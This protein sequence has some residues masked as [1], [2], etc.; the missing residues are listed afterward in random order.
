M[1]ACA[2]AGPALISLTGVAR[3]YSSGALEV[4]ALKGV[5]LSIQA[6][7]MVAIVGASGSGKSTLMNLLGC[8][9]VPSQG[10][11][12]ID[13]VA[14]R[15]LSLDALARLRR[16]R[17]GFIFQRY[18]LIR[19]QD[20]L[21][22]VCMP[23]IYA[24]VPAAQRRER[25]GALLARLGLSDRMDHRPSEL[26]GGQQ[27]RVSIARALMN[28]G[29][30][31]LADEPTGA[32]DSRSGRD[33]VDLLKELNQQGHTVII[34]THDAAVAAHA[35]RVIKLEDGRVIS[36]S[37]W[38]AD[39]QRMRFEAKPA[40]ATSRGLRWR[41]VAQAWNAVSMAGVALARHR[42]RTLL[43]TL[44]IGVGIAAVVGVMA[45]GDAMRSSIEK[46]MRSFIGNKLTVVS[47][48]LDMLPGQV[49]KPFSEEDV[50]AL[51]QLE[52]VKAVR[53]K[54]EIQLTAR[55]DRR[56]EDL[57]V[58]GLAPADLASQGH[59]LQQG[60]DI[61]ELDQQ[62]RNQV[63]VLNFK[64]AQLFFPQVAKPVGRTIALGRL[65]FEVIGVTD[66]GL[67]TSMDASWRPMALVPDATLVV[68]ML[69]RTD[70]NELTVYMAEGAQPSNVQAQ[71][72]RVLAQRHGQT[73]F[74]VFN[75][76][77]QLREA[78]QASDMMRLVLT[79]IASISLLVGG[80]GVM[81]MMLVAVSERTSEIGIRMAVG[82]RPADVQTQFLVES[83]VLC[84]LGGLLGLALSWWVVWGINQF[85]ADLHAV[86]SWHAM[87]T[88]F[89]VSSAIGLVFG[90]VPARQA[91]RMS[92]VAALSR[93]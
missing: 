16:E 85:Q 48:S 87:A 88:A 59:V 40:P 80:V 60:R 36:D 9:D 18:H 73:D 70:V 31:V 79:A 15:T 20:A 53:P 51:R 65:P 24:G 81:N 23:A 50:Q 76:E 84:G 3:S 90:G 27:Q 22:N 34:I 17:F 1:S 47:G 69:G 11:L 71:V 2:L 5:N 62:A 64:A 39:R 55:H 44:G 91:S 77:T 28:G 68:K 25:A 52:H 66:P 6:G 92:P 14:V 45:L 89:A 56:S 8:L 7:E 41:P 10:E 29:D 57:S 35:P 12:C 4:Q 46:S 61:S 42:L 93:E 67:S 83:M 21:A 49:T 38:P 32:L 13:G 86:L 72:S 30:I 37:G 78:S 33:M 82:A 26:S 74:M 19:E 75:R 63:V 54:R 43:S 58:Q